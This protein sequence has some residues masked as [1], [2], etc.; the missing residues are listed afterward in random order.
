VCLRISFLILN[1]LVFKKYFFWDLKRTLNLVNTFDDDTV[2]NG[3]EQ[4][5]A[6][7]EKQI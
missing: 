5:P 3:H 6:V 1:T 4:H 7:I 2:T